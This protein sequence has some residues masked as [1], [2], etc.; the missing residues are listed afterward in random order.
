M[1]PGVAR[2]FTPTLNAWNGRAFAHGF[3]HPSPAALEHRGSVKE[4]LSKWPDLLKHLES[5]D[6]LTHDPDKK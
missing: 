1:P 3:I 2:K 4:Y 6:P 5:Y